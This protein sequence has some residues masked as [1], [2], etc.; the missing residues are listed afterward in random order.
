MSY[1]HD[2]IN[3]RVLA[4]RFIWSDEHALS[5]IP[6]EVSDK[7]IQQYLYTIHGDAISLQEV[8]DLRTKDIPD[9]KPIR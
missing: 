5:L 4:D 3:W 2:P 7:E 1:Q 8:K 9:K 6:E